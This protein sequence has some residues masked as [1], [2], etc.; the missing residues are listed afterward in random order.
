MGFFSP[1]VY[2]AG[3]PTGAISVLCE[4]GQDRHPCHVLTRIPS[5]IRSL[6]PSEITGRQGMIQ[7]VE[8]DIVRNNDEKESRMDGLYTSTMEDHAGR[9]WIN[10]NRI[11]HTKDCDSDSTQKSL[12]LGNSAVLVCVL[13][14]PT[15]YE[16]IS[17]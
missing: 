2:F 7:V 15:P 14:D 3:L 9:L 12:S 6:D 10:L 11:W 1:R 5:E 17:T 8:G 4:Y 13:L 16:P